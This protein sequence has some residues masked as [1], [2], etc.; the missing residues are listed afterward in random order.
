[1]ED[2]VFFT[3][4]G[5]ECME[6]TYGSKTPAVGI[7]SG[8]GDGERAYE[9]GKYVNSLSAESAGAAGTT[10]GAGSDLFLPEALRNSHWGDEGGSTNRGTPSNDWATFSPMGAPSTRHEVDPSHWV[11]E[12]IAEGSGEDPTIP[13][14]N[15]TSPGWEAFSLGTC[16]SSLT[17]ETS[18]S[19]G[20]APD[21][22]DRSLNDTS[23]RHCRSNET[24]L[25]DNGATTAHHCVTVLR[26]CFTVAAHTSD[27]HTQG[28]VERGSIVAREGRPHL[29]AAECVGDWQ[30][31]RNDRCVHY[32]Y[33]L[34]VLPLLAGVP[35]ICRALYVNTSQLKLVVLA[36]Y[37]PS[38]LYSG[39]YTCLFF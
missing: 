7:W 32:F 20:D 17:D 23:S 24:E 19:G 21:T 36:T 30:C 34:R 35:C 38:D 9:P 31:L 2:S 18:E 12:T 29:V 4:G 3:E 8:L 26:S 13:S 10:N 28:G 6:E 37:G 5:G 1:M 15:D 25:L 11:Q 22:A 27:C 33:L 16:T 39:V 14:T